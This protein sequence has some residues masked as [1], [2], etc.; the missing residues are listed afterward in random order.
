MKNQIFVGFMIFQKKLF[1]S[2]MTYATNN[3]STD[4]EAEK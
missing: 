3:R 1:S 2:K 4:F